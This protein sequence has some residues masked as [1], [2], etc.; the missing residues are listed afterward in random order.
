MG[1]LNVTPD[2]FSDGG[3]YFTTQSAVDQA[4]RLE[5]QGA[6]I[7]DIGG[8]STRPY[9]QAVDADD[10]LQRVV[11]IVE[12]LQGR[13]GIP[14]SIDTT[15]ASVAA[16]ALDLGVEIINDVSGLSFDPKMIEL[17]RETSA[18]VCAMH[19]RGT[20]QNMQDNPTYGDVVADVR[21]YLKTRDRWL[22][23]QG[24]APERICLDPGIGFGKTH[25]HNW[26]L[27]RNVESFHQLGRPLL[28]GHSRKGFIAKV[29]GNKDT[30][31]TFG[32][33]GVSIALSIHRVQIL[34]VH[35]IA[36]NKQA[37]ELF[38]ESQN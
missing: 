23:E 6:D 32:T 27:V 3:K 38:M 36:A 9:S 16:A 21:S 24:V 13:I 15:K 4:K 11:P 35:D 10:E 26:S 20:P 5:D 12:K 8:E 31:R 22:V 29:L 30:D 1:I 14:I 17:A 2:S 19:M 34:R 25:E 33:I 7:L 18:G 28:V 37:L